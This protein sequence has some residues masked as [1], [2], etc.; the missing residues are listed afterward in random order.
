MQASGG[1]TVYF[2]MIAERAGLTTW[3]N[4]TASDGRWPAV[5]QDPPYLLEL[6]VR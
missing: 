1:I 5:E 4:D 2:F 6:I 3:I